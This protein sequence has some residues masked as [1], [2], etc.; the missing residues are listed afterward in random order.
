MEP[1]LTSDSPPV[2]LVVAFG[3]FASVWNVVVALVSCS[4][5]QFDIILKWWFMCWIIFIV[6]LF[7]YINFFSER[8]NCCSFKKPKCKKINICNRRDE[9]QMD[10][11]HYTPSFHPLTHFLIV[12]IIS[13]ESLESALSMFPLI[14][15]VPVVRLNLSLLVTFLSWGWLSPA[16]KHCRFLGPEHEFQAV[17]PWSTCLY[18][19]S[20]KA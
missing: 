17:N 19:A 7:S 5:L 16:P 3:R 14:Q 4:L 20:K 11:Y 18:L 12:H 9:D 15:R 8:V 13:H 1:F 10:Y 2:S 6:Y